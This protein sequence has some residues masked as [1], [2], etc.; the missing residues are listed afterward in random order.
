MTFIIVTSL[1]GH[2]IFYI[3]PFFAILRGKRVFLTVCIC[4]GLGLI[5][6]NTLCIGI[7][8]LVRSFD[9]ELAKEM[10]R[11]WVPDGIVGGACLVVGWL[12]PLIGA[13]IGK[14]AKGILESRYPVI[15]ERIR[16]F[17]KK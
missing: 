10:S 8:L 7:P 9:R 3:Y 11:N 2:L 6:I 4:W 15:L 17:G 14:L 5:Y 1:I 13:L 16:Q 12:P